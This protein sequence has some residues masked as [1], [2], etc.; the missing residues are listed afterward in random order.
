MGCA[1][2]HQRLVPVQ[3]RGQLHALSP[4]RGTAVAGQDGEWGPAMGQGK[5][6]T[7]GIRGSEVLGSAGRAEPVTEV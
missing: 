7:Q 3:H 5:V 1:V 4:S 2:H 6:G